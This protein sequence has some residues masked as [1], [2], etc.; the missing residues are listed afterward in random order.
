MSPSFAE[1][2]CL[3]VGHL[4]RHSPYTRAE[5]AASRTEYWKIDLGTAVDDQS[6]RIQ[7]EP[8]GA[9]VVRMFLNGIGARPRPA[10]RLL[11]GAAAILAPPP[12]QPAIVEIPGPVAPSPPPI[13]NVPAVAP[14]APQQQPAAPAPPLNIEEQVI[15]DIIQALLNN[16][17]PPN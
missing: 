13:G 3:L 10:D 6:V 4:V 15:N 17:N 16:P 9:N 8:P 1:N 2:D 14:P 12:R 5:L 11:P 7:R